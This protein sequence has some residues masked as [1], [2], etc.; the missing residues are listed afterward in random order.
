MKFCRYIFFVIL[1]FSNGIHAKT[2]DQETSNYGAIEKSQD[3]YSTNLLAVG[4]NIMNSSISRGYA[5]FNLGSLPREIEVDSVQLM[6][7][8]RSS[9]SGSNQPINLYVF[10]AR[11]FSASARESDF[12]LL[13]EGVNFGQ[14]TFVRDESFVDGITGLDGLAQQIEALRNSGASSIGIGLVRNPERGSLAEFYLAPRLIMEYEGEDPVPDPDPDPRPPLADPADPKFYVH[15]RLLSTNLFKAYWPRID[16]A[17]YYAIDLPN[18]EC[19]AVTTDTDWRTYIPRESFDTFEI[20][21]KAY[22]GSPDCQGEVIEDSGRVAFCQNNPHHELCFNIN[23]THDPVNNRLKV[24]YPDIATNFIIKVNDERCFQTYGPEIN[25]RDI[26]LADLPDLKVTVKAH[27]GF[28]FSWTCSGTEPVRESLPTPFCFSNPH[29][30][31]CTHLWDFY[32]PFYDKDRRESGVKEGEYKR[33]L[34]YSEVCQAPIAVISKHFDNQR[35]A[36]FFGPGAIRFMEDRDRIEYF[37]TW[38]GLK[39]A[40]SACRDYALKY[41]CPPMLTD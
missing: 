30:G 4:T 23:M 27:N 8:N 14:L 15:T 32:T 40:S 17:D 5:V 10:D 25:L 35:R 2:F 9:V 7:L 41:L 1:L 39:C 21:V 36:R 18:D 13:V 6:G 28:F 19:H 26:S 33:L 31:S 16:D 11:G 3:L 24:S 12:D 29:H 20:R 22:K 37:D 38:Q 34:N